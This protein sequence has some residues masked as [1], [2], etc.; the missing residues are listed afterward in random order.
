[1]NDISAHAYQGHPP[2][3]KLFIADRDVTD[4]VDSVDK[5]EN[6]LDY[7]EL[8]KW[9]PGEC[10]V[11]LIDP[12][13]IFSPSNESNFF[14]GRGLPQSGDLVEF[15]VQWGFSVDGQDILEDAFIGKITKIRQLLEGFT[16]IVAN[17]AI[18]ELFTKDISDF[19]ISRQF[20][21]RLHE[22][23]GVRG[24]YPVSDFALPI[25][26]KSVSVKK[27]ASED[28]NEVDQVSSTGVYD[29][30]NYAVS[31][32]AI[33][34]E[35]VSLPDA[36]LGFPQVVL[37]SA[38]RDRDV[39][40]ILN[41]VLKEIE[42]E[43]SVIDIPDIAR[44]ANIARN[45]RIG[46][47]VIGN[48]SKGERPNEL[49]TWKGFPTDR[50][51][52]GNIEYSLYNSPISRDL[53]NR[54]DSLL[55]KHDKS[56]G[57]TTVLYRRKTEMWK[58]A[59]E[60][61]NIAILCTDS[62]LVDAEDTDYFFPDI[63]TKPAQGSYDCTQNVA[64]TY[65]QLYDEGDNTV[66]TLVPKTATLKAQV[67]MYYIFG[68]S[69]YRRVGEGYQIEKVNDIVPDSVRNFQIHNGHLYYFYGV[70]NTQK[71]HGV[72]KVSLNRG[73]PAAMFQIVSDG[74]SHLGGNFIVAD[75]KVYYL[76][77]NRDDVNSKIFVVSVNA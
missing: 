62:L 32:D 27:N 9:K 17:D 37:K 40:H 60:G 28:Y 10:Q 49:A 63:K 58:L 11:T 75:N 68:A 42:I 44:P 55:L 34:S 21:I 70:A 22:N 71:H 7:P 19:G 53:T 8:N 76:G 66:F 45:G 20:R 51:I 52:E 2:A 23:Q 67:G 26:D 18:T 6:S 30:N 31:A 41:D 35:Y 46:Y 43:D 3:F 77:T 65:I 15:K 1:M 39:K 56:T 54:P 74:I 33:I 73:T 38:Y 5:I 16:T 50:I 29:D 57:E 25:S 13:G 69:D 47:D 4:Y 12:D 59:K 36:E 72:A 61:D 48:L 24:I 64:R 14:V